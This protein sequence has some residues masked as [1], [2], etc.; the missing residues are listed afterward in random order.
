ML[1]PVRKRAGSM[2]ETGTV[3]RNAGSTR[4]SAKVPKRN[5]GLNC[6]HLS[7]RKSQYTAI[8]RAVA[9]VA[10]SKYRMQKP[11]ANLLIKYERE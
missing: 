1:G 6:S 7:R 10:K 9:T 5:Q 4:L 2:T 3:K 11:I 8:K